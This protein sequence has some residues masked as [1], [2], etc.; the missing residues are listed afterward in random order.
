ML[1]DD[2]EFFLRFRDHVARLVRKPDGTTLPLEGCVLGLLGEIG[3][4]SE[5]VGEQK[6]LLPL[7]SIKRLREEVG[8]VWFYTQATLLCFAPDSV[9]G[10]LEIASLRPRLPSWS[11]HVQCALALAEVAKKHA[12]HGKPAVY[13]VV[14]GILADF[15][16]PPDT[17]WIRSCMEDNIAKLEARYPGGFVE[18]GGIR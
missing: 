1:E 18:G 2:N 7:V 4:V 16:G 17:A 6:R 11:R 14:V 15:V 9:A 10:L 8:D 12:W 13:D 3:E 5:L